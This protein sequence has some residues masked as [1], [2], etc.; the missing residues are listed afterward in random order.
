MKKAKLMLSA[1]GVCALLATAFAFKAQSFSK[2]ILYFNDGTGT[3]CTEPVEGKW[4]TTV[5]CPNPVRVSATSVSTNCPFT[6]IINVNN[7]Q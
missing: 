5:W 1:M 2:H 3:G 7:E 4:F 6:C